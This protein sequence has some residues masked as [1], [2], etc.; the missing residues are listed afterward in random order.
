MKNARFFSL[1]ATVVFVALFILAFKLN[2]SIKYDIPAPVSEKQA[3][4]EVNKP[5]V[6]VIDDE[7]IR[8]EIAKEIGEKPSSVEAIAVQE[9][10]EKKQEPVQREAVPVKA[11][12]MLVTAYCVVPKNASKKLK[13]L[14][15]GRK[16]ITSSGKKVKVGYVAADKRRYPYGTR[17]FIPDFGITVEV[18]DTGKKIRGNHIDI[19]TG[20]GWEALGDAADIGNNKHKVIVLASRDHQGSRR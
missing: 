4:A 13:K 1:Y 15:G 11:V 19:F 6:N 18:Q 17:M 16:G 9:E 7:P 10:A 20:W 3:Q 14:N 8:P 2:E 12:N 5:Q